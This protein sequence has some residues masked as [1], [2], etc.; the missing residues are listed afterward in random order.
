MREMPT[1]SHLGDTQAPWACWYGS[2]AI[3]GAF[4]CRESGRLL[5]GLSLCLRVTS[6]NSWGRDGLCE[7][8]LDE[9]L[10]YQEG[11]RVE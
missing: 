9:A 6:S 2:R 7:S 1:L 4:L 11:S 8:S 10:E 5:A 3:W